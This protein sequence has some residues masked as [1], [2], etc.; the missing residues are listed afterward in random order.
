MESLSVAELEQMLD[1]RRAELTA[2]TTRR[3]KLASELAE[4]DARIGQLE[5]TRSGA[6][7]GGKVALRKKPG[8]GR[9]RKQP[10]LKKIIVEVLQKSKKPLS[11]D[12]IVDR[13]QATGYKSSSDEF[14]KVAY[15]NLFHLKKDGEIEHDPSTKLYSVKSA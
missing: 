3:V 6:R 4:C 10:A 1:H 14:R 15:L 13:V 8:G 11:V 9:G 5:G 7:K 2:L 12:E